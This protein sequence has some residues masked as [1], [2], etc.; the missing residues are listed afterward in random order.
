[1][2]IDKRK[3]EKK[4]TCYFVAQLVVVTSSFYVGLFM[5]LLQVVRNAGEVLLQFGIDC[6][7]AW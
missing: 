1:M 3:P 6:A 4:T 5:G 2:E 7:F